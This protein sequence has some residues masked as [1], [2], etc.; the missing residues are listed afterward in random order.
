MDGILPGDGGMAP[1]LEPLAKQVCNRV[2]MCHSCFP[3]FRD[4]GTQVCGDRARNFPVPPHPI[5]V[6][7]Y[8]VFNGIQRERRRKNLILNKFFA[9]IRFQ[10]GYGRF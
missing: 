2:I 3:R 4:L 1:E 7:K 6:K 9:E 10:K 8:P 5:S